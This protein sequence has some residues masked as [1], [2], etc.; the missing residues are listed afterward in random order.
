MSQLLIARRYAKALVESREAGTSLDAIQKELADIDALVRGNADLTRLA[1]DPL[2][3]PSQKAEA[4]DQVLAAAKVS[5]VVRRF[6]RAVAQ[7][8]RL[9][10]IHDIVTAFNERMDER[11]GIVN[12]FVQSPQALNETQSKALAT[13]L[14]QR[15]GKTVR[16]K[17]D[18]DASLLGGVK[19]QVGSTIYDASLLG[20]L[21]QLKT[22]LLSV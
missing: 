1:Q 5:D 20:Q 8:A 15:T 9:N 10:L 11:M 3:A 16:L 19:V 17:W 12:A 4:F 18:R 21:Q 6:F 13:S 14:S 7:G 2:I 22:R